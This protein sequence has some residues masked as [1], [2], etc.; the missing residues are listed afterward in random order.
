M[1]RP[2]PKDL[3]AADVIA[4]LAGVTLKDTI[5]VMLASDMVA[6]YFNITFEQLL[7]DA[8][9]TLTS[10]RPAPEHVAACEQTFFA[11]QTAVTS[12]NAYRKRRNMM[13]NFK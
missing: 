11:V 3:R 1:E 7:D 10:A 5:R 2:M 4:K 6:W 12:D 9:P 8:V 13:K